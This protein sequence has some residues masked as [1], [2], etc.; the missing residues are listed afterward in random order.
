MRHSE[1]IVLSLKKRKGE[2]ANL[3][4]QKKINNNAKEKISE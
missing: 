3:T 4:V 2:M 1:I